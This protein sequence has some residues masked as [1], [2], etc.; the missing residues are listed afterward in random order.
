[1]PPDPRRTL[2]DPKAVGIRTGSARHPDPSTPLY[3]ATADALDRLSC[4]TVLVDRRGR[5]TYSNRS[6]ET[7][8]GQGIDI[9]R[10]HLTAEDSASNSCLQQLIASA[11]S[12]QFVT[13]REASRPVVI[14]RLGRRPLLIEALPAVERTYAPFAHGHALLM[15]T[16]CEDRSPSDA[17]RLQMTFRLT[18]SET[19]LAVQLSSGK[20]FAEAAEVLGIAYETSRSQLKSVFAKTGTRRQAELARL[21]ARVAR[22]S[23]GG[24]A[25]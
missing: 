7:L 25:E 5:A 6:A 3:R 8:F 14:R 11:T 20:T 24:I 15:I 19:R 12:A 2:M 23:S 13:N 9:K 4:G 21:L 1:M 18:D 10:G 16:D 17:A 22:V